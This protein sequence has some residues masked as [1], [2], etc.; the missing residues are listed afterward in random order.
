MNFWQTVTLWK[1]AIGASQ[2]SI[3]RFINDVIV[4]PRFD[5]LVDF[6]R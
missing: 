2:I 4:K 1:I 6:G 3:Q 5:Q